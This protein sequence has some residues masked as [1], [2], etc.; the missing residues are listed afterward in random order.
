[1]QNPDREE[2]DLSSDWLSLSEA[3]RILGV[4]PATLRHWADQGAIKLLR[5]PGGH[6]RFS[7]RDIQGFLASHHPSP[8]PEKYLENALQQARA[9]LTSP[10]LEKQAWH[11]SFS[12]A[13]KERRRE[14]G[15]RLLGLLMQYL[16]NGGGEREKALDEARSVVREYGKDAAH[17]GLT[18]RETAQAFL[19]FRDFLV[20]SALQ[21]FEEGGWERG[22][23]AYLEINRF[24]NELL[25]AMIDAYEKAAA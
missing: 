24:M 14:S 8:A 15:R 13:E 1:M 18:S 22:H 12:S 6:R 20:E 25:L 19:F 11:R 17:R 9:L 23:R 10:A 7:L 16:S 3:S 5:T 4:H 21:T 2:V